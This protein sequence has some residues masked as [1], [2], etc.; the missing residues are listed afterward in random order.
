MQM[1]MLMLTFLLY[2]LNLVKASILAAS[3][4]EACLE[5]GRQENAGGDE[6]EQLSC[7][8]KFVVTLSV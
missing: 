7:S 8:Q 6:E 4:L 3:S 1:A 2:S 5:D